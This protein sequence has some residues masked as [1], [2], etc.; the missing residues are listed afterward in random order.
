M[1][2]EEIIEMKGVCPYCE[3]EHIRE[4][5]FMRLYYD[6]ELEEVFGNCGQ[7]GRE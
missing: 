2:L 7:C 3:F 5:D 6:D 1:T 4:E